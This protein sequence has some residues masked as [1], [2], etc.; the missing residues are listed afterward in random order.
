MNIFNPVILMTI[1]VDI[2][3]IVFIMILIMNNRREE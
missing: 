1:A 3:V 2:S